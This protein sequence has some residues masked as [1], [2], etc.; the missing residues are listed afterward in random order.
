M[1]LFNVYRQDEPI[2]MGEKFTKIDG[3][4][5]RAMAFTWHRA[6]LT[7]VGE[8]DSMEEARALAAAPIL[9]RK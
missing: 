3:E 9:E 2:P 1:K 5:W 7:K 6:N 8:A 4:S